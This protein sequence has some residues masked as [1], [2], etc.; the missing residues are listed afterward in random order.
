MD[1]T[2]LYETTIDYRNLERCYFHICRGRKQFSRRAVEFEMARELNLVRLWR[3]MKRQR[4][5]PGPYH[6]FA[7]YEP[8]KRIISIPDFEDRIVQMAVHRTLLTFYQPKYIKHSYACVRGRSLQM[9]VEQIRR[10]MGDVLRRSGDAWVLRMDVRSFFGSIDR[11]VLKEILRKK[12][13]DPA[14]QNLLETIIDSSPEGERGLPVGSVTSHDFA[15]IYLDRLDQ[16][17]TRFLKIGTYV[18]YVDDVILVVESREKAKEVS[19]QVRA[20]LEDRLHLK[21]NEKTRIAEAVRGVSVCGYRIFPT[22]MTVRRQAV[23]RMR[24]KMK[25][26]HRKYQDGQV[27]QGAIR[28]SA[29]SWVGYARKS[30]S[31]L[32]TK[33]LF[34]PYDYIQVEQE[35]KWFGGPGPSRKHGDQNG[36]QALGTEGDRAGNAGT[37]GRDQ[38]EKGKKEGKT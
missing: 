10:N 6:R 19:R 23:T 12:S 17:V 18:R 1:Q 37:A 32:I 38:G 2:A 3:R 13:P 31:Y 11:E 5:R 28:Q 22:H 7:V 20:F 15:N 24:R 26:L 34:E 29:Y 9:A 33:R 21:L 27:S 25:K 30:N 8:R 36:R 16:Y 4:Y 35:G 14:F